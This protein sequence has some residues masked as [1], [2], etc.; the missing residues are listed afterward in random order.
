MLYLLDAFTNMIREIFGMIKSIIVHLLHYSTTNKDLIIK[1]NLSLVISK[2]DTR[3]CSWK[4]TATPA[5]PVTMTTPPNAS[6][7][8]TR[9][10][11]SSLIRVPTHRHLTNAPTRSPLS[12]CP[13]AAHAQ[14]S[15]K[16][17]Y[18]RNRKWPR[19]KP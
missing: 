15:R 10:P 16:K 1:F 7:S 12:T 4:P 6:P 9:S 3:T 8:I 19:R 14:S 2:I 5:A 17:Y 18:R 13:L 11:F